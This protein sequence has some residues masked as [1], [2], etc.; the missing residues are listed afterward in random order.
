MH[1]LGNEMRQTLSNVGSFV[2]NAGAQLSNS[3]EGNPMSA[4]QKQTAGRWHTGTDSVF[5]TLEISFTIDGATVV[6][7]RN[8]G[9]YCSKSPSSRRFRS[10]PRHMP[11]PSGFKASASPQPR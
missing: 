11:R 9:D 3:A 1:L 2:T 5:Q 8:V 10:I 7:G 6:N 4:M